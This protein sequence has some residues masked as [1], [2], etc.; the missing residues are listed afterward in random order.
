MVFQEMGAQSQST[1][2]AYRRAGTVP[3]TSFVPV[4]ACGIETMIFPIVTDEETEAQGGQAHLPWFPSEQGAQAG[5]EPR[6]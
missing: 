4:A 1:A 2:Q 6:Q 3:D 5:F